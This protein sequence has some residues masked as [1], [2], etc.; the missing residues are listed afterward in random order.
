M[1]YTYF[2][3]LTL[4]L[5]IQSHDHTDFNTIS[6]SY[7]LNYFNII[8]LVQC[9]WWYCLTNKLKVRKRIN[10]TKMWLSCAT[11][12]EWIWPS[13]FL[14]LFLPRNQKK[15]LKHYRYIDTNR[16]Q[17]SNISHSTDI[18]KATLDTWSAAT[19]VSLRINVRTQCFCENK[20]FLR[21]SNYSPWIWFWW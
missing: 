3:R 16:G 17:Q 11:M 21:I 7:F 5:R 9:N 18:H 4:S 14:R 15:E 6:I 13:F 1:S 12:T 19:F 8:F 20:K 10:G 2:F